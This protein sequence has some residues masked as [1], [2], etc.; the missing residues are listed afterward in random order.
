MNVG[1]WKT[2]Q[3]ERKYMYSKSRAGIQVMVLEDGP[4]VVAQIQ[5]SHFHEI[6]FH[7]IISKELYLAQV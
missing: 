2:G 6:H 3:S 5:A 7:E 1:T 4:Q